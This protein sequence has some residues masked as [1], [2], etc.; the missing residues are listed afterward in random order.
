MPVLLAQRGKERDQAPS[1]LLL[2]FA[3]AVLAA[4]P[5]AQHED[6]SGRDLVAHLVVANDD[7]A[8]FA[9]LIGFQLLAD[10]RLIEQPIGRMAWLLD[11]AR[12]RPGLYLAQNPV[13]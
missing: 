2:R 11:H 13:Q 8:D 10:P 3:V 12:C 9:R 7:Q 4:M 6:G 5:D 1:P